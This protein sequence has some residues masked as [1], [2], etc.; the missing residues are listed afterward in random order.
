ME[1]EYTAQNKS[2]K[3]TIATLLLVSIASVGWTLDKQDLEKRLQKLTLKFEEL[4]KKD[5]RVPPDK[6]A[7]AEGMVLLDRTKAGFIFAY[8][9]GSGVA[10]VKDKASGEWSPVAFVS[11]N[12]GSLGFQ[13]GGQKSFLVMLLMDTNATRMLTDSNFEFGGEA[14]GTA[15]ASSAGVDG[16]VNSGEVPVLVF[17]DREGLF[18]GAALKGGALAPDDNANSIYYGSDNS[19]KDILFGKKVQRTE[20]AATLAAK[21]KEN[22]KK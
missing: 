2:I 22:S 12:E 13:I 17:D 5:K 1:R 20:G 14:Q 4:Q 7:K 3:K 18:G 6:L 16:V 19:M 10:M 15:G 11:A 8:Q 21:I 9:G